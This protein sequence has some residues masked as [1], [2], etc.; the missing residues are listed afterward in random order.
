MK[1]QERTQNDHNEVMLEIKVLDKTE[2][3]RWREIANRALGQAVP[4]GQN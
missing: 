3:K 2:G 4:G 1:P